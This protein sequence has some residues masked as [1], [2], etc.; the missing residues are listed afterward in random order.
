MQRQLDA[1]FVMSSCQISGKHE[2]M[3][4]AV[5][6][7]HF[8]TIGTIGVVII[9]KLEDICSPWKDQDIFSGS[10]PSVT[11]QDTWA[12]APSFIM[13]SPKLRGRILGG[14]DKE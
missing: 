5:Q 11:M 10:S 12:N 6:C 13:A 9:P 3:E 2:N 1:S 14:T 7:C 4:Y 8:V